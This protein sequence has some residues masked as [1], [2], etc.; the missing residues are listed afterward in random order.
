MHDSMPNGQSQ[1]DSDNVHATLNGY[2]HF[3]QVAALRELMNV[4]QWVAYNSAKKP[5]D[6]STGSGAD[7]DDKFTWS[8]FRNAA[9]MHAGVGFELGEDSAIRVYVFVD[10]DDC[11]HA[12]GTLE[13]WV[14]RDV[15]QLNSYTEV[16]PSGSG[17]H[18]VLR[19]QL[20]GKNLGHSEPADGIEMYDHARYMTVTGKHYPGTPTSIE[21]RPEV[22]EAIYRRTVAARGIETESRAFRN[23]EQR[24]KMPPERG[25]KPRAGGI[26]WH[27]LRVR[28]RR[29]FPRHPIS[30]PWRR[31]SIWMR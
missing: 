21:S 31:R 26:S 25:S 2:S 30:A 10:Y 15:A 22:V 20:S 12:D 7:C 17:L 23:R 1:A 27:L 3:E 6:P 28:F 29:P 13:P 11:F 9:E 19:G 14:A 16:S 24:G 4:P 8:T 5:L 18:V